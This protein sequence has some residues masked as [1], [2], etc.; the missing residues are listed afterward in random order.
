MLYV[1]A[2][3]LKERACPGKCCAAAENIG[4]LSIVAEGRFR[5]F[6][7]RRWSGAARLR[8]GY[9]VFL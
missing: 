3:S 1:C 2:M 5:G 4:P 7:A 8:C 6:L 9:A